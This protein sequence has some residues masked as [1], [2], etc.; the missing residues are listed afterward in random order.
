LAT[1]I[2]AKLKAGR[3]VTKIIVIGD[4]EGSVSAALRILTEQD[5]QEAGWA[6][7]AMLEKHDAELNPANADL[8]ESEKF[9]ELIRRFLIDPETKKPVFASAAEVRETLSRDERNALA[10]DYF[11]FEKEHSPSDRTMSEADFVALLETVKKKPE[12][13]ALNGLSGA[14]LRRLVLSLASQPKS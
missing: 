9:T 4:G 10:D 3:S 14:T 11:D 13:P 7:N 6:A 12:M 5:H 8:F 1:D 2:L